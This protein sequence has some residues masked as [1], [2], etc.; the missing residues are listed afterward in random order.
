MSNAVHNIVN[1]RPSAS[2][3]T[4]QVSSRRMGSHGIN[5]FLIGVKKVDL[6][7]MTF[8]GKGVCVNKWHMK[9]IDYKTRIDCRIYS[10]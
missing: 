8:R 9:E 2:V 10:F 5:R 1:W 7:D 4:S 6:L 3:F